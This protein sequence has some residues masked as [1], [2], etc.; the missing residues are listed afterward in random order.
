[1]NVQTVKQTQADRLMLYRTAVWVLLLAA[2]MVLASGCAGAPKPVK[3]KGEISAVETLNPDYQG[4]PSPVKI[5]VVQLKSADAFNNADFFSLF[6]AES[7]VLGGDEL[8]RTEMLLQPG[9]TREWVPEFD[10]ETE[11][12]G[13]V[14]AFR[15][16]ENAQWRAS[17]AVV[18]R[19]ITAKIMRKKNLKIAVDALA[20]SVSTE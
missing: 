13:V 1:M 11:F 20:V 4:R 19:G 16:I 15:D 3:V 7:G 5:I 6:D 14:G 17:A 2:V 8:A 18:E 9:E 10:P 12:V